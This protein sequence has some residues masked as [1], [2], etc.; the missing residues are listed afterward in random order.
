VPA[1]ISTGCVGVRLSGVGPQA[2]MDWMTFY[3]HRMLHSTLSYLN[4]MQYE[5]RWYE[6]Q[7]KK[8]A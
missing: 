5:Q 6:A 8:A 4:P 7:R 3:N 2:V 1:G